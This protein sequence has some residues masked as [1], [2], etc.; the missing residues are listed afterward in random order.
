MLERYLLVSVAYYHP[1]V[2]LSWR[3]KAE[4]LGAALAGRDFEVGTIH[5][6]L[7]IEKSQLMITAFMVGSCQLLIATDI[8][9]RGIGNQ[10]V[11]L[12]VNF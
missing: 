9:S 6:Q 11:S 2:S 7:E 10:Y 12:C 4:G 1:I 3:R 5:G 8:I